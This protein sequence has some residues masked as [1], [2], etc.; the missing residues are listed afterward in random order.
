MAAKSVT[1]DEVHQSTLDSNDFV[2]VDT[3]CIAFGKERDKWS[4]VSFTSNSYLFHETDIVINSFLMCITLNLVQERSV[5]TDEFGKKEDEAKRPTKH[6]SEA[7]I[8]DI[9]PEPPQIRT[10]GSNDDIHDIESMDGGSDNN[11]ESQP[12]D[13]MKQSDTSVQV[14]SSSFGRCIGKFL[15]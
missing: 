1:D 8:N 7:K 13:S 5:A 2:G 15:M 10:P 6:A 12:N 4:Q 3:E 11:S 14:E 9:V